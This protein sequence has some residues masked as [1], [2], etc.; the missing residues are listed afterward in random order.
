MAKRRIN[1][2]GS[3]IY[4]KDRKIWV[5]R[6]PV[7]LQAR[8]GAKTISAKTQKELLVKIDELYKEKEKYTAKNNGLTITDI[9]LNYEKDKLNKNIVQ[10][11]TYTR[12]IFTL[13][14]IQNST[15]N[16]IPIQKVTE[17]DLNDFSEQITKYSQSTID[18]M[19]TQ[20]KKAYDIAL[21]NGNIT[22]NILTMYVKPQSIKK[23][24]KVSAFTINEQKE[25]IRLIPNSIYYMQYLIALNTGMRMGEINAL[26]VD[27]I[28]LINRKINVNKTVSRDEK[29]KEYINYN[30][31]TKNGQRNIPINDILYIPLKEY[32][33]D[34]EG[35]LFSYDRVISTAMVNSE[36]KRL[37]TNNDII[38]NDVNTHMLRHTFATRCIESG[39]PA[40]VLAKILG[41]SDIS[42]TLN[43]YTDVFNKF[44]TDHFEKATIYFKK[45][46]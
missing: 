38:K 17:S 13:S 5:Y 46:Y 29:Y 26:H 22:K 2:S 43:T 25:F 1:N 27:D 20:I 4:R 19:F 32:I 41:H 31:K 14:I 8:A 16:N 3:I 42:T 40:V 28:D 30:T 24:K 21:Y 11:S 15:L 34:K 35:F 6:I 44:K 7:N 36:M 9:I 33:S 10:I 45:L 39:M 18:K 23:T 37:C 12:N